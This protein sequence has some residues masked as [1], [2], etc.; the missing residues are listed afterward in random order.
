MTELAF[1]E[2]DFIKTTTVFPFFVK[3]RKDLVEKARDFAGNLPLVSPDNLAK[4]VVD[5]VKRNRREIYI[6]GFT[7]MLTLGK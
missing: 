7:K 1:Y 4:V 5:G 2:L 3:T 6:P